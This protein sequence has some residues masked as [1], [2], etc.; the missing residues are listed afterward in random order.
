MSR[1]HRPV[2]RAEIATLVGLPPVRVE[3]IV[4]RLLEV[5]VL[6]EGTMTDAPARGDSADPRARP[7]RRSSERPRTR[8][9]S[10][11]L[12]SS[13]TN[14]FG[15]DR[16]SIG[17]ALRPTTPPGLAADEA[18]AAR[19][20][21]ETACRGLTAPV[22]AKTAQH[23]TGTELLA[24]CHDS[25]PQT[26]LALLANPAF[27]VVHARVVAHYHQNVT[28]LDLLA[29]RADLLRDVLVQRAFLG[30]PR[31]TAALVEQVLAA[32]TLEDLF[33][34]VIDTN[35]AAE[36]RQL[37]GE[38]LRTRF[39]AASS[40][41]RADLVYWSEGRAL[42]C[43]GGWTLDEETATRIAQRPITSTELV[44]RL[45]TYPGTPRALLVALDR[46]PFVAVR[47]DLRELIRR[48]PNAR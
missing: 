9:S 20:Q 43:S 28:G 39:G 4:A 6:T 12:R 17:G 24:F 33:Q 23:A 36:L 25:H 14:V 46:Q 7:P 5:G 16:P 2:T 15:D 47:R 35:L 22:R 44:T 45:A 40:R 3:S 42:E 1:L 27:A 11:A 48:H 29:R 41:E 37:V 21:Y 8:S 34:H 26:V 18:L 10:S 32:A 30:N 19:E 31:S 38:A 13:S